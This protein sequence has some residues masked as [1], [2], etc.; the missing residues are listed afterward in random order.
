ML[1]RR[2]CIFSHVSQDGARDATSTAA[3]SSSET[4]SYR[5]NSTELQQTLTVGGPLAAAAVATRA[6]YHCKQFT[7]TPATT[8]VSCSSSST[9]SGHAAAAVAAAICATKHASCRFC[10]PSGAALFNSAWVHEVKWVT[11]GRLVAPTRR[12]RLS[13]L[14]GSHPSICTSISVFRRRLASCSPVMPYSTPTG[15][16]NHCINHLFVHTCMQS[17]V[18]HSL[19]RLPSFLPSN[20]SFLCGRPFISSIIH[21]RTHDSCIQ[22][23]MYARV[24][25]TKSQLGLTCGTYHN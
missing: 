4:T 1:P 23:L 6:S 14:L 18:A 9:S 3:L 11:S 20:P 25:S 22:L 16:S 10:H 17:L 5:L 13:A 24:P 21:S 12:T 2:R 8:A 7:A 15:P 19:I